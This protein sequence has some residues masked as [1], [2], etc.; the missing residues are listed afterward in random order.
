MTLAP[1]LGQ[2]L[3]K[4]RCGWTKFLDICS[5]SAVGAAPGSSRFRRLMPSVS[6]VRRRSGRM[7]GGGSWTARAP[8]GPGAT[9]KMAAGP[10]SSSRRRGRNRMLPGTQASPDAAQRRRPQGAL[11]GIGKGARDDDDSRWP[12]CRSPSQRR[13]AHPSCRPVALRI[14]ER[15]HVGKRR[16]CRSVA[17]R[18][19]GH[20]R[21]LRLARDR[22]LAMQDSA[23]RRSSGAA[24]SANHVRPRPGEPPSLQ[25]VC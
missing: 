22:V 4:R 3:P 9:K 11:Q 15:A 19:P 12:V 5:G 10:R 20:Q 6:M 14:L 17:D 1:R 2:A 21:R 24:P 25:Q 8:S 18:R 7:S 23:R 16:T 13:G